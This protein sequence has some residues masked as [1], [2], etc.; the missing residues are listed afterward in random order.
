M[1]THTDI[2]KVQRKLKENPDKFIRSFALEV[3]GR[4][5]KRT[6]VDTGRAR[7]NWH[8][9][10][11][12]PDWSVTDAT[13]KLPLH[14]LPGPAKA[15]EFKGV[16]N[17]ATF[18]KPVWI[19]NGLPYIKRLEDGWSE[20]ARNPNGMVRLVLAELQP[21]ADAVEITIERSNV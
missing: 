6:P 21:L 7:G 11:D 15:L 16:A 5:V 9:S 2:A 19:C 10:I 12:A 3:V 13:D 1:S 20:Q 18:G 17:T 8:M 14:S 4:I